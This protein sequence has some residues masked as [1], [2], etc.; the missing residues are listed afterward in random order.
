MAYA[1][2]KIKLPDGTTRD[3]H[4]LIMERHLGRT[5]LTSEHV[6][7]IDENK[8]NNQLSNLLLISN[9]DHAKEHLTGVPKTELCKQNLSNALKG[10][11]I[12]EY[13]HKHIL[14]NVQVVEIKKLL[15]TN[16]TQREIGEMFGVNCK[17]ISGINVGTTW[18]HI[19]ID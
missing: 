17:T 12:G 11:Y 6:H 14:T 19:V 1:Y 2:K 3:E 15:K 13:S 8:R 5:L 4:R 9:S 10:K 18:K 16:I 7:H